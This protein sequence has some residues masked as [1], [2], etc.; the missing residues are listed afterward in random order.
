VDCVLAGLNFNLCGFQHLCGAQTDRGSRLRCRTC[1]RRTY[2]IADRE[3]SSD[4]D[5]V[6]CERRTGV[7]LRQSR[8]T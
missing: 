4:M 8:H 2:C 5:T 1:S 3:C 7:P 6:R